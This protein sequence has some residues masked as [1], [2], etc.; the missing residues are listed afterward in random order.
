MATVKKKLTQTACEKAPPNTKVWD[1]E[2]K[3][4]G[5][6][7][8]KASKTFYFQYD[9]RGRTQ[10]VKL[11]NFPQVSAGIA[12]GDALQ[13][14]ADQA[15]GLSAKRLALEKVPTLERAMTT[16]LAR[17]KL[18]S[19]ANKKLVEGQMRNHLSKWLQTPLDEI[20]KAM[21]VSS[22]SRI[23][24]TGERGANHVLKSFR[25]I[26][27]HT[28]RT[29]D[30]PE[31]PTMAIEWYEEQASIKI[32]DDLDAWREEVNQLPNDV[33]RAFYRF[34]LLTGLRREEAL[35][36]RWD[37]IHETHLH[38]PET[39]NGRAFD[40]PL[41]AEHHAIIE[42]MKLYRSD[43]VFHGK[44]QV[45]HLREPAR[46]KW[47]PHA[48]RRTFATVATTDAGLF[49]ETVGRLLNHTPTS[50]TGKHYVVSSH[51]RLRQPMAEVVA[52]FKRKDLI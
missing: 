38:L 23:A 1:T 47:S 9:V 34:L 8:G 21:C 49:E 5:L 14:A 48:H 51:E 15:S 52:A 17:P 43:Y 18:R 44:K 4:F 41:L 25:S 22:H 28:R 46:L 50:V 45:L 7:T 2:I 19:E 37:Q 11:G 27:N 10:R 12:R 29:I 42:P 6:F 35:S 40:L 32:I 30:L 3:G 33:H 16:Y 36:L 20:T 24:K 13:L 39:K 31:C 26:Y